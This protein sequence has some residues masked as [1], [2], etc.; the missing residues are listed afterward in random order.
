VAASSICADAEIAK[1][2]RNAK[3]KNN[4]S[5]FNGSLLAMGKSKR[6]LPDDGRKAQSAAAAEAH[7]LACRDINNTAA[8]PVAAGNVTAQI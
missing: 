2:K 7:V 5:L 4:L 8:E 1:Q 3:N 6:T